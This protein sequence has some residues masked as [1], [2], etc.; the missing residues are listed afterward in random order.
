MKATFV[1]AFVILTLGTLPVW[2][3][4]ITVP[5]AGTPLRQAILNDLRAAE[6]IASI[7]REQKKKIIFEKVTLRVSGDWAWFSAAPLTEDRTWQ[8]EPMNGLMHHEHGHWKVAE[9][10]PDYVN[11]ADDA[12]KAYE[13]WRA[14]LLKKNAQ[15]PAELVPVT[16]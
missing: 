8:T 11:S 9:Y 12:K 15:C 14:K 5:P 3:A 6:P 13:S 7:A 16:F 2:T 1:C 4:G 10:V